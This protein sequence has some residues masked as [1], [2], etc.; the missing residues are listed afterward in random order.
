[1]GD[2]EPLEGLYYCLGKI[3]KGISM[4]VKSKVGYM[5]SEKEAVA[6]WKEMGEQELG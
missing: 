4:L 6:R 1:M 2:R 3:R 5:R